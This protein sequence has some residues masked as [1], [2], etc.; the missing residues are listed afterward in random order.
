MHMFSNVATVIH[1][2]SM[3]MPPVKEIDF[4]IGLD[5]ENNIDY[6]SSLV[7]KAISSHESSLPC[8]LSR[9]NSDRVNLTNNAT[10]MV[11]LHFRAIYRVFFCIIPMT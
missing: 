2:K 10:Y 7:N 6:A 11:F 9:Y 8:W 3:H 5:V 4:A 1:Q